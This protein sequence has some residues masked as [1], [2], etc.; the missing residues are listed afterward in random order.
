M[1]V[2]TAG[3]L[4]RYVISIYTLYHKNQYKLYVKHANMPSCCSPAWCYMN[5]L[6][7]LVWLH[8]LN[9]YHLGPQDMSKATLRAEFELTAGLW[10]GLMWA[11]GS[12]PKL[13]AF[14]CA[15][16]LGKLLKMLLPIM[17]SVKREKTTTVFFSQPMRELGPPRFQGF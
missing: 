7:M 11:R 8:L 9:R 15:N 12:D 1:L 5:I 6:H 17:R 14:L 4:Q 16:P 3:Q 2:L 13:P 10:V